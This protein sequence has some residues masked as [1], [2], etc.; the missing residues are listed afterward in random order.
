MR[1]NRGLYSLFCLVSLYSVR[2]AQAF[3]DVTI[4]LEG[5]TLT[6]H[7][8]RTMTRVIQ[9]Y[10]ELDSNIV[11]HLADISFVDGLNQ[12]FRTVRSSFNQVRFSPWTAILR[13]SRNVIQTR[14]RESFDQMVSRQEQSPTLRQATSQPGFSVPDHVVRS[15]I[16]PRRVNH[17]VLSLAA[18]TDSLEPVS[19]TL[20]STSASHRVEVSSAVEGSQ[21]ASVASESVVSEPVRPHVRRLPAAPVPSESS[22]SLFS[23][24]A[25]KTVRGRSRQARHLVYRSLDSDTDPS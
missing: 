6:P 20:P 15:P 17:S 16:G 22:L 18:V 24:V 5:S 14:L 8:V 25:F 3:P 12:S 13:S 9:S 1:V 4:P 2:G 23:R 10:M 11:S 21:S 7:V 19:S